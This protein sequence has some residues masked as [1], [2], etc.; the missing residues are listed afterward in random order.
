MLSVAHLHGFDMDIVEFNVAE[1][2]RIC[3]APL[4]KLDPSFYGKILIGAIYRDGQWKI[5]MG[6]TQVQPGDKAIAVCGSFM[7]KDLQQLF[8]D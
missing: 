6:D 1:G 5:A 7:L 2:A 3:K 4:K 8:L